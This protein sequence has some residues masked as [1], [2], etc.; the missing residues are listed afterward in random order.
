MRTR[1]LGVLATL[2]LVMA[3]EVVVTGA[4]PGSSHPGR[5]PLRAQA[6]P[7]AGTR[8]VGVAAASARV[9]AV[10]PFTNISQDAGDD[11][12]GD[13]IAE[14]LVLELQRAS[15]ASVMGREQVG[16]ALRAIGVPGAESIDDGH[17]VEVGRRLGVRWVMTGGYQRL[18]D[19]LRITGQ[20][21]DVRTSTV[22]GAAMVDGTIAD[23]FALQDRMADE[24]VA[25]TGA[26]TRRAS[27]GPAPRVPAVSPR[28]GEVDTASAGLAPAADTVVATPPA[29]STTSSEV[30]TGGFAAAPG[31]IDGPPP[32]VP[33]EVIS[34]DARGRATIR[35]TRLTDGIRLDGL[36]DERVYQTVP[37]ITGFIQQA[38]DE[39]APATEKTEAWIMFDADNLY[40]AG[41]IWDSAPPSEWVAN[42]MRH[43][44][45][46]LRQNDTFALILDTFYDRRNGVA[47]YSNPLGAIADFAITNEGNPNSDWN[48]VWDVRTARFEGGWTVEM[49]IPF[50]SLRYRPGS[51]QVWGVQL[52]RNV[53]RKNEWTYI[54]PLPISAGS[55]PGGIFRVSEAATLVGLEVPR[56]ARNLEIKPYGIGG[57]RTDV[58]ASPLTNNAGDGDFGFDVKYGITQNLTVDLTYNTDFAQVE[59]DEQQVNLTRFRLFFPEKREFF[60]EGRGIFDFARG[61]ITGGGRWRVA[62]GWQR[63]WLLRLGKRPDHLLQSTDRPAER[64]GGPDHRR[65]ARH[66]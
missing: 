41:R 43:D 50:R 11:W 46:Q 20:L 34:R 45:P 15:S 33:P 54:T 6:T 52:R 10:I 19:L 36:L 12:I 7:P 25:A 1:W 63:R 24:L 30:G 57:V 64:N 35:A 3:C 38:P 51:N 53:R 2:S 59:V 18:G 16:A 55:G 49:E 47:F 61:G 26:R 42:E 28:L 58:N 66:R 23:L 29:V 22:V 27:G 9:I 8:A 40:P 39:G 62:P 31:A 4:A 17:L 65:R 5:R 44:T 60:L 56:G 13:G 14:T 21:I 48:P 32:P 37:A